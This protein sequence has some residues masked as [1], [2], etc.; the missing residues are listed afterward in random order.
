[1]QRP[2]PA[3][4]ASGEWRE[5][6]EGTR[7]S[8]RD[9]VGGVTKEGW[10]APPSECVV[11]SEGISPGSLAC[12]RAP[13][14]DATCGHPRSLASPPAV[15]PARPSVVHEN[16]LRFSVLL[17]A[18]PL[19][20]SMPPVL[21]TASPEASSPPGN[22]LPRRDSDASSLRRRSRT[23]TRS[24]APRHSRTSNAP[25]AGSSAKYESDAGESFLDFDDAPPLPSPPAPAIHDEPEEMTP[26]ER[27]EAKKHRR[28]SRTVGPEA[29]SPLKMEHLAPGTQMPRSWSAL[30]VRDPASPVEQVRG[31]QAKS[32][33][34]SIKG[35]R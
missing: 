16:E 5:R 23:R 3:S 32:D 12:N 15:S 18:C 11:S 25:L 33:T 30:D 29:R 27:H 2:A 10:D 20:L 26:H 1:M 24:V 9:G 4:S 17:V 13:E 34:G 21:A 8:G 14:R 6:E 19:A 31:R 7:G 22:P 35:V 28:R